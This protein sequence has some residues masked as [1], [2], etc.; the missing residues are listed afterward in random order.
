MMFYFGSMIGELITIRDYNLKTHKMQETLQNTYFNERF[1]R[2]DFEPILTRDDLNKELSYIMKYME[3][4]EEKIVYSKG[5]YQYF[6]SDILE[7][8]IVCT[9]GQEDKKLLLF[10]NFMCVD[11]GTLMGT[12]SAEVI[13]QMRKCN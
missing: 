9:I 12:V 3:K 8:D 7:D 5:L 10:D 2:S 4:T 6:I 1:G 13:E 11:E